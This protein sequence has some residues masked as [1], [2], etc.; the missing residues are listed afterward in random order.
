MQVVMAAGTITFYIIKFQRLMARSA[1]NALML[2]YQFIPGAVM[3]KRY[4]FNIDLPSCR[5]MAERTVG[6]KVLPVRILPK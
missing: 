5:S 1:T 6:F 3:I 2:A 4:T